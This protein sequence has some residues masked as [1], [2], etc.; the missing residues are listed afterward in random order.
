MFLKIIKIFKRTVI[1]QDNDFVYEARIV[2]LLFYCAR[3]F[4][5]IE[6]KGSEWIVAFFNRSFVNIHCAILQKFKKNS[7]ALC[8]LALVCCTNKKSEGHIVVLP[9]V[10]RKNT[11]TNCLIV[12][13]KT[14]RWQHWNYYLKAM[15]NCLLDVRFRWVSAQSL[16]FCKL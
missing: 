12:S 10:F 14:S 15:V 13:I 3:D 5:D 4:R 8:T 9:S 7:L 11:E 6:Y 1:S 16:T 2:L